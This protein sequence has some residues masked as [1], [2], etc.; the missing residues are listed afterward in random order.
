MVDPATFTPFVGF[1]MLMTIAIAALQDRWA[2]KRYKPTVAELLQ[3]DGELRV[4]VSSGQDRV[5]YLEWQLGEEG[6]EEARSGLED[7]LAAARKQ[8]AA[9]QQLLADGVPDAEHR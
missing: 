3:P 4:L 1:L 9:S 8:L 6:D 7:R 2:A 5:E